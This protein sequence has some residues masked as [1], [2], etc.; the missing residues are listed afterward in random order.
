[1]YGVDIPAA[2]STL[3]PF[4]QILANHKGDVSNITAPPFVLSSKSVVEIP[5]SWACHQSRFIAQGADER[6]ERR[7]LAVL[8][9]FLASLKAQQYTGRT[10]AEGIKK[11]IN[12]F[13][14]EVFLAEYVE[15]DNVTMLISEQV[16]HHPP[17]TACYLYN[18]QKGI[19]AEG[20]VRQKVTFSF[21]SGVTIRQIG[22]AIIH[23]DKYQ[24]DH[25]M[26]LP[27]LNIKGV[28]TGTPYPELAGTCSIASSSGYT[29]KITFRGSTFGFGSKNQVQAVLT[30]DKAPE[31]PLFE[32]V[33]S[34][35]N[36]LVV[37][38][39]QTDEVIETIVIDSLEVSELK[40]A[41][42]DK[43]D[44]WESRKAWGPTIEGIL[45]G[46]LKKVSKAKGKI[47]EAQR[48]MR[49]IEKTDNKTWTRLFFQR[50]LEHP[51]FQR[52]AEQIKESLH[53][54]ETDGIWRFIGID[55][56]EGLE[57]PYHPGLTPAGQ[58]KA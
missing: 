37:K 24:E 31:K 29:S 8:I 34:W 58:L 52:L 3:I 20:Y 17:V 35:N 44:P 48:E 13:L 14:G 51:L 11:P 1:M 32:V 56:A 5:S 50:Q 25:L 30:S 18:E 28:L 54:E 27:V 19:H 21:S 23:I 26:T 57:R 15:G 12:P 41:P 9:N 47:E 38:D 16:S 2:I 53:L 43:Q 42:I 45:Q 4:K 33:G 22:H 7:A 40:V 36:T 49:K 46:D 55:A 10:E 6:P 39:C